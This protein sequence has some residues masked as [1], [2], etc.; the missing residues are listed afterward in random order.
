MLN[1]IVLDMH[2]M[3]NSYRKELLVVRSCE[4]ENV[5]MEVVI[6]FTVGDPSLQCRLLL[7]K[8]TLRSHAF[9]SAL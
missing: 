9:N 2:A 8:I 6:A 5:I 4:Y 3:I 1:F 7:N